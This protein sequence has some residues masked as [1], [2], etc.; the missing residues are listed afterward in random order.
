MLRAPSTRVL[1]RLPRLRRHAIT[2]A[3]TAVAL[4]AAPGLDPV[5]AGQ[6]GPRTSTSAA[7]QS[8]AARTNTSIRF[9]DFDH[10]RGWSQFAYV[11]GQVTAT[12]GGTHGALKSA[13]VKLYRKLDSQATF[14][15]LAT[16]STGT[17]PYPHFTF[18]TRAIG[19]SVYKVVYA[20]NSDYQRTAG[21]TRILV[22]RSMRAD[23]EDQSGRFH[24]AARPKYVHRAVYLER[25]PCASCPWRKVRSTRT[26]PYGAFRFFV[27]AP[28][29]GRYWWRASTPATGRFIWSYTDVF[30]TQLS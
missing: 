8:A 20:G 19:N 7:L 12:N 27:S 21:S 18:R 24:G 3:V 17:R 26:G 23:L 2:I 25:R 14:H 11:R 22:H 15:Y 1:P 29:T 9:L 5:A 4:L 10:T 30:T 28:R 13:R 6:S 16:R